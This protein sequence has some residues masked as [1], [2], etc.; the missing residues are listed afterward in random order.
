MISLDII[1]PQKF[2]NALPDVVEEA[3]IKNH[4]LFLRGGGQVQAY[5]DEVTH[6]EEKE[7]TIGS[8]EYVDWASIKFLLLNV[9]RPC[10]LNIGE[11]QVLIGFDFSLPF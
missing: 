2:A 5:L 7:I 1:Y 11:N 3:H 6:T 8:Q 10:V 9:T 4:C